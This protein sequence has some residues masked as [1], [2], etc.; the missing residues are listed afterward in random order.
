MFQKPFKL[1]FFRVLLFREHGYLIN[2]DF[3]ESVIA[4]KSVK[5]VKGLFADD[6]S[7][8]GIDVGAPRPV[9]PFLLHHVNFVRNL[10]KHFLGTF[11]NL[12]QILLIFLKNGRQSP[13][14][15]SFFILGLSKQTIQ[16][17]Q[18][19]N[20]KKCQVHPVYGAG[21]LTHHLLN[22]IRLP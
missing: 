5:I 21:I 16:F 8:V 19:I 13:A 12:F 9:D 18:Q 1:Y 4:E 15:F 10:L 3:V 2:E 17:L 6:D 14:S 20:V 11:K 7:V 22:M